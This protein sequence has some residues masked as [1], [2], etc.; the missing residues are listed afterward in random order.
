VKLSA[1]AN[2]KQVDKFGVRLQKVDGIAKKLGKVL[3]GVFAIATV[4]KII[5]VGEA[6]EK[7][8]NDLASLTG[9]MV[10]AKMRMQE[11][12]GVAKSSA[13]TTQQMTNAFIALKSHGLD[14]TANFMQS[15]GQFASYAG[16]NIET[17]AKALERAS[18]GRMR[19]IGELLGTKVTMDGD[20]VFATINGELVESQKGIKGFMRELERIQGSEWAK[21]NK[22]NLDTM[23]SAMNKLKDVGERSARAIAEGFAGDLPIAVNKFAEAVYRLMLVFALFGKVVGSLLDTLLPAFEWLISLGD[24][25]T[26]VL[27]DIEDWI[28]GIVVAL[29]ALKLAAVIG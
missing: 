11:L 2:T 8:Q 29:G 18:L 4:K 7:Q 9:S 27:G 16:S 25:Y 14:P 1:L 10:V 15:M 3:A 17:V 24:K 19:R 6:Y 22:R 12:E 13:F 5:N 20:R 23:S 26:L 28:A 21:A